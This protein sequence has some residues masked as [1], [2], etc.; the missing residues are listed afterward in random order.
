VEATN[1]TVF[2][3]AQSGSN[4]FKV[5]LDLPA[6]V[7][8]LFPGMYVKTAFMV[9]KQ[10]RLTVPQQAVVF[11][12]EVTGVYVVDKDGKLTFRHIRLGEKLADNRVAILA[13][14]EQKEQIAI[15]PIAAGAALKQQMQNSEESNGE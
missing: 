4:T 7:S 14:L 9:G 12:S 10:K 3:Y 13:G 2:P 1:I 11:R 15:D 5:R 8:G 6:S